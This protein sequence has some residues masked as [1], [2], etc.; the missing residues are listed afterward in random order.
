[1]IEKM[2]VLDKPDDALCASDTFIPQTGVPG[3]AIR[4]GVEKAARQV[5]RLEGLKT[6]FVGLMARK[7]GTNDIEGRANKIFKEERQRCLTK[8]GEVMRDET[9]VLDLLKVTYKGIKKNIVKGRLHLSKEYE[10]W[11]ADEKTVRDTKR[12]R[13]MKGEL[14]SWVKAGRK[15]ENDKKDSKIKRLIEVHKSKPTMKSRRVMDQDRL[16]AVKYK[17]EDMVKAGVV[18]DA[19][20]GNGIEKLVAGDVNRDEDEKAVLGLPL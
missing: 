10:R 1:M 18:I 9:L 14:S 16:G 8:S 2:E 6:F 13:I 20:D 5:G 7:V 19:A 4:A 3:E 15:E 17:D 12:E 11:I